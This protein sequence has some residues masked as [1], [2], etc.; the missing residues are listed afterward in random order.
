MLKEVAKHIPEIY[1]FCHL[2]YAG[3]SILRFDTYSINS[4]QG[5]QQGDP[6][7]PLLFCLSLHPILQSTS[8]DLTI[9][10]LDDVT[11]GGEINLVVHDVELIRQEGAKIAL[12]FNATKYELILPDQS[13]N[14][15]C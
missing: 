3:G 2:A 7:G 10:Y 13:T 5:A 15:Y 11:L 9:G 6:L 14:P 12:K 1:K 8:V 4:E